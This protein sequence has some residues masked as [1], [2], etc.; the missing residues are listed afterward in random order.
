MKSKYELVKTINVG[1]RVQYAAKFLRSIGVQCGD[2]CFVTGTVVGEKNRIAYV[3]WDDSYTQHYG[4][5]PELQTYRSNCE[6]Q[7]I[8]KGNLINVAYKAYERVD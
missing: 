5:D 1:D 2:M 7:H 4:I 6:L 3:R 8:A